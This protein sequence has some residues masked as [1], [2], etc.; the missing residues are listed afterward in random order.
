MA[1]IPVSPPLLVPLELTTI[2]AC[3]VAVLPI[4]VGLFPQQGAVAPTSLE[5]RFHH[6]KEPYLFYNKGL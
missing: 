3:S 6:C 4:A 2:A 1:A 5:S